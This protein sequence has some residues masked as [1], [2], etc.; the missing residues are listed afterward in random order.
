MANAKAWNAALEA[1]ADGYTSD[2]FEFLRI[3]SVSTDPARAGAVRDAAEWVV[4]RLKRAGVPEAGLVE[5]AGHPVVMAR[6]DG[7]ADAPTILVYGHYDVQPPDPLPLWESDPFEP[8]VRD[9]LIYARGSADMKANLANLIEGM[10]V[11]A[12]A[13]G[14]RPPVNLIFLLEGEEE[15]GSP[16][17]PKIVQQYR[18]QLKAD[19][20]LSADG[21]MNGFESP[22][23]AIGLKGLA[24]CQI[25]VV[26]STTDLHSGG[27]GA[28]VPNA[29]QALVQLASTFHNPDGS[30]AIAGFYDDV[31][32]L[33]QAER[34]EIAA[35]PYDEAE[36]L[37]EAGV[38]KTWGEP[39]Y[40]VTERRWTRPTVDFNGVWG[41]FQGAG[42]KTVTPAEAHIKVTCRLVPG[43]D[44]EKI[45][46]LIEAHVAANIT[47]GVKATVQRSAGSAR[48]FLVDRSNPALA[49]AHHVLAEIYGKE[50]LYVRSGGTVP[51]TEVFTKELGLDTVTLGWGM[52]G[53][54]AHAPNEWFRLADLPIARRTFARFF[55]A[56][57]EDNAR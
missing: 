52:P 12:E 2:L 47:P 35:V 11:L 46:D 31:R 49:T 50:P 29:V 8:T 33:T 41:G 57:A 6:W 40:T 3:P 4:A 44:P 36:F 23:L 34:D 22:S 56:M 14:G 10:E 55:E 24:G 19:V 26:S 38:T 18:D 32:P 42:T 43:Q 1:R 7:L 20:V 39:G 9:G 21:G 54:K 45:L 17:L 37:A 15:I 5:T 28:A 27:Y 30:V 13:S 51:I 48:P 16:N 25:D 53:S